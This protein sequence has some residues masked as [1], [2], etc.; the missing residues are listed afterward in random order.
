LV[1]ERRGM[2]ADLDRFGPPEAYGQPPRTG[3]HVFDLLAAIFAIGISVVSLVVAF[4]GETTQRGLLAANSWPFVQLSEDQTLHEAKLDVENA[5]VGPAKIMT[6]EVSYNG[7]PVD[8]AIDLLR[9]CCGLPP[10]GPHDAVGGFEYGAVFNNV[11]RPGEHIIAIQLR[12]DSSS[13]TV[14]SQFAHEMAHM[15]FAICY[16]SVLGECWTSNLRD[17]TQ[18]PLRSCPAAQH[19]FV[20][21]SGP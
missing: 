13:P 8:S 3:R 14:Y 20:D 5:G 18:I 2:E 10:A 4:R 17:L 11:L 16:C 15:S 7:K 12:K 19:Q 9:K 6:F 1:K 21:S